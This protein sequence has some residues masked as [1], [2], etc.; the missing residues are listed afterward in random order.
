MNK[1]TLLALGGLVALT[2]NACGNS[3][4]EQPEKKTSMTSY[5]KPGAATRTTFNDLELKQ[6]GDQGVVQVKIKLT[7]NADTLNVSLAGKG[8]DI[9]GATTF[10]YADVV[11]GTELAIDVPVIA[12]AMGEGKLIVS[13][14]T[15]IAAKTR[16]RAVAAIVQVGP[17]VS[18][19]AP[20][21]TYSN[22]RAESLTYS[23][24]K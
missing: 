4:T 15:S 12:T 22:G 2:T 14:S 21:V 5:Q 17:V 20:P 7:A 18:K 19:P 24:G 23:D 16:S 1:I 11:N 9:Q 10:D 13:T 6:V 8:V 3:T